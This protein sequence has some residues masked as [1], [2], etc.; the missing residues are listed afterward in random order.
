MAR[1]LAAEFGKAVIQPP[2]RERPA[3]D[4]AHD[5]NCRTLAGW[6]CRVG[7][8]DDLEAEEEDTDLEPGEE[9]EAEDFATGADPMLEADIPAGEAE[10]VLEEAEGVLEEDEV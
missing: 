10:G 8:D 4:R 5:V 7:T 9:L 3:G 6:R 1:G 2:G